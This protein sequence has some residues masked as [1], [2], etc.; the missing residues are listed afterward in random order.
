V[1]WAQ[2]RRGAPGREG[3]GLHGRL[4]LANVQ[5]LRLRHRVVHAHAWAAE[6]RAGS[7][8]GRPRTRP[9]NG[10]SS[11]AV[12]ART[13]RVPH[14]QQPAVLAVLRA[15]AGHSARGG[16]AAVRRT[17][18]RAA[19]RSANPATAALRTRCAAACTASCGAG[20]ARTAAAWRARRTWGHRRRTPTRWRPRG[21]ALFC[22]GTRAERFASVRGVSRTT[23]RCHTHTRQSRVSAARTKQLQRRRLRHGWRRARAVLSG[24]EEGGASRPEAR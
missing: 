10:R 13:V 14:R 22:E 3:H 12:G 2:R 11:P 1:R 16:G 19:R 7:V 9:K 23:A 15:C 18:A 8:S 6:E 17:H 21:R 24:A 4:A 5:Q 20:G